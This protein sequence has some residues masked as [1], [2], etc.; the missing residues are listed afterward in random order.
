MVYKSATRGTLPR[1]H[2]LSMLLT[3]DE[4]RLIER[5]RQVCRQSR[6]AVIIVHPGEC[7]RWQVAEKVE[8]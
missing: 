4:V 5:L 3:R 8:S 1:D 7:L 6:D 2:K